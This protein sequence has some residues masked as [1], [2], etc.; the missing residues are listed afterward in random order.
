MPCYTSIGSAVGSQGN[1]SLIMI[2]GD[3][4]DEVVRLTTDKNLILSGGWNSD[5]TTQS[6]KTGINAL[7]AANG[8]FITEGIVLNGP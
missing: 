6:M 8:T 4:Y 2:T 5:Y 7:T 3:E 1:G